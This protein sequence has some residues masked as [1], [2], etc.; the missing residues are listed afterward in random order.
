MTPTLA[1]EA[2]ISR[3]TTI[4]AVEFPTG[5]NEFHKMKHALPTSHTGRR[6]YVSDSAAV[7]MGAN[8]TPRKKMEKTIWPV[9]ASTPRSRV[10]SC[11]AGA[12]MDA[13]MVVMSWLVEQMTP[14]V[15]LR[16]D[17]QLYGME[18]SSSVSSGEL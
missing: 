13:A 5:H 18:G 2:D 16:R 12:I 15:I 11:S 6:P 14:M 3:P 8:P 1:P 7:N 17:G 10:M 9:V 4:M